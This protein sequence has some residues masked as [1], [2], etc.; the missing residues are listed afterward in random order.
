MLIFPLAF[1]R[2]RLSLLALGSFKN[3][4]W[5]I[6]ITCAHL[7]TGHPPL[8]LAETYALCVLFSGKT[9]TGEPPS[10]EMLPRIM[11]VRDRDVG[12]TDCEA[13]SVV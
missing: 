4:G 13:D 2:E 12:G 8:G 7:G 3:S 10:V 11:H 6:H 1:V 5:D 9:P